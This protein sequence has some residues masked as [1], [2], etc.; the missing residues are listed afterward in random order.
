MQSQSREALEAYGEE[1]KR[2]IREG[3][4]TSVFQPIVSLRDG[5]VLGYE[6]LSRG[7]AGTEMECPDMLFSVA[8]EVH[9]IW[10]LER[11][12]RTRALSAFTHAHV[13]SLL[14]L[15]V[16]PNVIEDAKFQKGFTRDYLG[17]FGIGPDRVVFEITERTAAVNM[18]EFKEVIRYYIRQQYKIAIDDAGAG[19]SGLNL[20][21]DLN[22]QYL[23]LDMQ[24]IRGIDHD[25]VKQAL[26]KSLQEFA[27]VTGTYLI[28]EGIETREELEKLIH[29]GVHYGQGYYIKRPD[30]S[31]MGVPEDVAATISDINGKKNHLYGYSLSDVYIGNLTYPAPS[32]NE[33]V[34][35]QEVHAM[36]IRNSL[37]GFCVT[38]EGI[39][40][41]VVTRHTVNEAVSGAYGFSLNAKKPIS[42][43]MERN[44]LALDHQMPVPFAGKLAMARPDS[45]VYDFITVTRNGQYYGIVTIKDLLIKT[46]E[47][48]V[49]NATQLNPLTSLPGNPLIERA[50]SN[51]LCQ[52]QESCVLYFDI[53]N[54]K[55][56]ND[57]YGFENGDRVIQHLADR[58]REALPEGEFLGHVGGD[59]F[60]VICGGK[61]VETLCRNIIRRF[62]ETVRS[63]YNAKDAE[64]GYILTK[65][66][67]GIEEHFPIISLSV[68]GVRSQPGRFLDIYALSAD[69]SRIKKECKQI[70]GSACLI[71]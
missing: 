43:I 38:N 40:R 12:C 29:I 47:I 15:N 6:A 5:S 2:I 54:F 9:E 26:V 49:N 57:V 27:K 70:P 59:D 31:L 24:L 67:Q 45:M 42:S 41:G 3:E 33:K 51:M 55:A 46:I 13:D 28:A 48:E 68:A 66:R 4:I 71:E 63:F 58:I 65:N 50:L 39:V 19:Y 34:M 16:N 20:I 22:P 36:L 52:R 44:F 11:L 62:D 61:H 23:K 32:V 60:V 18:V 37:Q 30:P 69:A 56:Y 17:Q 64:N 7:P 25:T 53:D 35:V 14:F 1:L 8:E 21:T 10:E